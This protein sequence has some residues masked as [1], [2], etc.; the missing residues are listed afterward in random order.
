MSL[1]IIVP[2]MNEE[3][4]LERTLASITSQGHE[5][6]VVDGGS[7]DDTME[8][9][10]RYTPILLNSDRG[11]GIQQH[12]GACNAHGDVLLFLHADTRPP[13]GFDIIIERTLS[14]TKVAFGAFHLGHDPSSAFLKLVALMANLRS[15]LLKMP[16]G[17]QGLF[18]RWSDYFL[19]RG[20]KDLPI[21]EDVDLV[22]RLKRTGRFKLARAKVRTSS[23]RYD[24]EGVFHTTV[25]NWSIIIRYLLGQS[26]Q[27]LHRRYSD[28][29]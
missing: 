29:R 9:A 14:D 5:I 7:Q 26:P 24:R 6:I 23:R 25:R 19:V 22:R 28:A 27:R 21:M 2:T 20:F 1:S 16:Y 4:E 3:I 17:D 10:R 13:E 11:R 8:I 18:M 15:V 12:T